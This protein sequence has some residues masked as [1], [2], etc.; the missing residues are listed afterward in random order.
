MTSQIAHDRKGG[1]IHWQCSLC[2]HE[3]M[4]APLGVQLMFRGG[5]EYVFTYDNSLVTLRILLSSPAVGLFKSH[6]LG[7]DVLAVGRRMGYSHGAVYRRRS[8]LLRGS[9][10]LKLLPLFLSEN[11]GENARPRPAFNRFGL[12]LFVRDYTLT[13]NSL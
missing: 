3:G 5:Q 7:P 9:R 4:T 6:D 13:L 8:T 11:R 2:R 12:A 1:L 10:L